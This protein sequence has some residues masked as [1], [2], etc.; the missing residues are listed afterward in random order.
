MSI[1]V[2][3]RKKWPVSGRSH[4][5]SC[6][7]WEIFMP[8]FHY[9]RIIKVLSQYSS[10]YPLVRRIVR[11]K[12]GEYFHASMGVSISTLR[13]EF[14]NYIQPF[15]DVV[16]KYGTHSVRSGAASNTACRRIPGDL[17]DMHAGWRC[18]SSK[19][20]YKGYYTVARRY[21]FYVRVARTISHEWAQRTSEILFL[22]REHK[23]HIFELT[24]YVLFI[25]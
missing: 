24:C 23:I 8:S 3:K 22:P 16:S 20:R 1:F 11:S 6:Q 7:V 5:L 10:S 14:K 15:V 25:I 13:E 17:L 2:T 21:E 4:L 9:W 19:N 12:S 18:P